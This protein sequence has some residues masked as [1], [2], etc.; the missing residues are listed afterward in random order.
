MTTEQATI[1]PLTKINLVLCLEAGEHGGGSLEAP[2]TFVYGIGVEGLTPFEYAL[3]GKKP[4]DTIQIHVDENQG[5]A[6][7]GHLFC[8]VAQAVAATPPWRLSA[9][10]TSVDSMNDRDLVKAMAQGGDC[11]GDCGCGCSC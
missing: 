7:F 9:R 10:V 4:G 8:A 3:A 6:V 2:L 11:Q 5:Q 1:V